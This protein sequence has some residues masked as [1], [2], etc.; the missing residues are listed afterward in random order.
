MC[1]CVCAHSI[2]ACGSQRTVWSWFPLPCFLDFWGLLNLDYQASV[3]STF[4]AEISHRPISIHF[5]KEGKTIA[6]FI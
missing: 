6:N 1:M 4:I 2:M 3:I 5:P